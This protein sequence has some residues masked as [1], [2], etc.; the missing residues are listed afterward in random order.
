MKT[1]WHPADVVAALHKKGLSLNKLSL[2][3]GYCTRT[4]SWALYRHYPRAEQIVASA[5]GLKP[6]KI[7]PSRYGRKGQ[8]TQRRKRKQTD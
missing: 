8:P 4:L 2:E 7:W 1:D 5:L 6:Q 3:N